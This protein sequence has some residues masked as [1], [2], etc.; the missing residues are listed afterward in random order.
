MQLHLPSSL[1][2][3]LWERH[4]HWLRLPGEFLFPPTS[5]PLSHATKHSPVQSEHSARAYL[6]HIALASKSACTRPDSVPY[7]MRL[8]RF[9]L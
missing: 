5:I 1:L 6:S 7:S 9:L 8:K 4:L 2:W 3:S